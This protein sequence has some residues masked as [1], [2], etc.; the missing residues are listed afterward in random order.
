MIFDFVTISW[1]YH[2]VSIF[3]LTLVTY[4]LCVH[5]AQT[6]THVLRGRKIVHSIVNMNRFE[7][8]NFLNVFK[9]IFCKKTCEIIIF[10]VLCVHVSI[11]FNRSQALQVTYKFHYLLDLLRIYEL[12]MLHIKRNLQ[13]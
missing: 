9:M 2:D 6:Y 11:N 10:C 12:I 8:E 1:Q 5:I 7:V 3:R 4:P 13:Y